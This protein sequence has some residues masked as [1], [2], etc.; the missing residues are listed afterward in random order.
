MVTG[1]VLNCVIRN[2]NSRHRENGPLGH[3]FRRPGLQSDDETGCP[4]ELKK[5]GNHL[6]PS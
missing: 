4:I 3:L 1:A 6:P 2:Y 5:V